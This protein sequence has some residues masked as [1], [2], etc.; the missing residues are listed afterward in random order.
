MPVAPSLVDI[1]RAS[2]SDDVLGIIFAGDNDDKQS[3][4]KDNGVD[5]DDSAPEG[6]CI[7]CK[8]QQAQ[9]YC[10]QCQE[11]FCEVCAGMIH[12][13]GARRRHVLKPLSIVGVEQQVQPTGAMEEDTANGSRTGELQPAASE[14][15]DMSG[16]AAS[17]IEAGALGVSFSAQSGRVETSGNAAF[18]VWITERAKYI[19][20]RL[21]LRERKF[22]RLLEA[23]L[24]VSEYTDKIDI[25][26]YGNK[27]KR[28]VAQIKELCAIISGL[29]LASDYKVGQTLFEDRQFEDNEDFYQKIFEIGRR[30]KIMNPEKMRN[31][32]DV[33]AMLNFSLVT[34]I[35]TVYSVLESLG[36]LYILEDEMVAVATKEIIALGK[37]RAQ[38]QLEVKQKERAIEYL[39]KAYATGDCPAEV[40]RQ[41]LY[42]IGDNHAYLRF[43]RD[44]CDRMI[45]YLTACFTPQR[46]ENN[47]LSLAILHGQNGARL[48]HSHES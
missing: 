6:S 4:T 3:D 47:Q 23:G 35:K 9:V 18:S 36:V 34:P 14:D 32:S 42:S 13:T 17:A 21:T 46:A 26:M 20:I 40:I 5:G 10:E 30:H 7:E 33:K 39:C 24:K 2:A 11:D 27:T 19:P 22:L 43:N 44:P 15:E 29:V 31:D 41:C 1:L 25:L 28:I 48:S 37:S 38:I 12:R 16:E 45:D 8:D